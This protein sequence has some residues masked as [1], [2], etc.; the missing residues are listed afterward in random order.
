MTAATSTAPSESTSTIRPGCSVCAER[1]N[2][3]TAAPAK[4]LT[5]SPGNAT[6]PTVHTINTPGASAANHDCTTPNTRCTAPYTPDTA[7]PEDGLTSHITTSPPGRSAPPCDSASHDTTD[8]GSITFPAND[9]G[10]A[11]H[12]TSNNRSGPTAPTAAVNCATD[13]GRAT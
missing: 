5:S 13:T 1:T 8:T 7:P 10:T 2:P 9:S 4:S 12:T 11:D 6:A 3:H